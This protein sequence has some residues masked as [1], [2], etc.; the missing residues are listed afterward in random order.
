MGIGVPDSENGRFEE[1]GWAKSFETSGS[2]DRIYTWK[3]GEEPPIVDDNTN[4]GPGGNRNGSDTGD[5]RGT[6]GEGG[7]GG[8][9]MR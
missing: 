1:L 6:R 8:M 3:V 2:V 5:E 7:E 9:R 4:D